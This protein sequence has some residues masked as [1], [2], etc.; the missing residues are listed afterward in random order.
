M[1]L[2]HLP[3]IDHGVDLMNC[4]AWRRKP[5]FGAHDELLLCLIVETLYGVFVMQY[6]NVDLSSVYCV[7]NLWCIVGHLPDPS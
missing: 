6:A 4:C 7:N 1:S 3:V 5:L 2:W